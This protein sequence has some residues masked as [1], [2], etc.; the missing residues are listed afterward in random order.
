[1]I[2]LPLLRNQTNLAGT[3]ALVRLDLNAPIKEGRVRDDF[4]IRKSLDTINFLRQSGAYILALSHHSDEHQSLEPIVELL[5]AHVPAAFVGDIFSLDP[6]YVFDSIEPGTVLVAENI[7]FHSEEEANDELFAEKL[8][9]Y[10]DFFVNDAFSASHRAHAS[11]VGIPAFLPSSFGFLF[12]QEVL[13]L[14]EAFEP[15]HPFLLILG[16]IKFDTKLPLVVKFLEIAD[17]IFIG[18]A[19]G[20]P[21]LKLRGYEIGVS[22]SDTT[23]DL[24]ALAAGQN[25]LVPADVV[26][27]NG[28]N[29]STKSI[30]DVQSNDAIL[31]AGPMTVADLKKRAD[32]SA[33]ILWNGPLGDYEH[34][35]E[36]GTID[37]INALTSSKA[38]TVV[39]GGD[40]LALISHMHAEDKFSFVSSGGGAMLDFLANG[41]LPGIEAVTNKL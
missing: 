28:D 9:R 5:K 15:P 16:G 30:K 32:S 12:E 11:I 7:R 14:S 17:T 37:L 1:M 8:A 2:S 23:V 20:N 31:D 29:R 33:F 4:R 19:L 13:H 39:G 10:G 34:G 36:H 22:I 3:R 24:S 35:F 6:A 21:I 40:T 25:V 26:V 41:T 18:G 27:K 38:K